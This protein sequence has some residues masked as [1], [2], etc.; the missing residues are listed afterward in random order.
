M[1]WIEL[2]QVAAAAAVLFGAGVI[3]GAWFMAIAFV[4]R[5]DKAPKPD[6]KAEQRITA[7]SRHR[8]GRR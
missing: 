7:L 8:G 4:S 5:D 6:A 1:S 2:L 3:T